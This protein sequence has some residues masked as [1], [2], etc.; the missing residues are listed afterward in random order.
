MSYRRLD[1]LEELELVTTEM[2]HRCDGLHYRRFRTKR[3]RNSVGSIDEECCTDVERV[4]NDPVDRLSEL[5]EEARFEQ[6]VDGPTGRYFVGVEPS[7]IAAETTASVSGRG[8]F[9]SQ[10]VTDD[11]HRPDRRR[12][13][14]ESERDGVAETRTEGEQ[15]DGEKEEQRATD[16]NVVCTR[17]L[18]RVDPR[19]DLQNEPGC[20]HHDRHRQYRDGP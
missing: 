9:M 14:E 19:G 12:D 18:R 4:S 5:F 15:V 8:P 13:R 16:D 10:R 3:Y 17:A 20:R 7:S 2:R 11:E 1:R 6:Q